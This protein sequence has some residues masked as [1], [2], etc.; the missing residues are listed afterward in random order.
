MIGVVMPSRRAHFSTS[1]PPTSLKSCTEG[2][3]FDQISAYSIVTWYST[4][5]LRLVGV[6]T[7]LLASQAQSANRRR[8]DWCAFFTQMTSPT[9]STPTVGSSTLPLL[10]SLTLYGTAHI[11]PAGGSV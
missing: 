9:W 3:F 11:I 4:V 5:L 6:H 1:L 8:F 10:A 7:S 2:T